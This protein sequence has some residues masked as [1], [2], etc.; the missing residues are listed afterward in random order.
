MVS[1]LLI[2]DLDYTLVR[3]NTTYEFLKLASPRRYMIFSKILFPL[4]LVNKIS[5]RDI[6]KRFLVFSCINQKRVEIL[7]N[8]AKAHFV[9]LLNNKSKHFNQ[10]VL[11][12]LEKND[13]AVILM[14][15]SLDIVAQ[16]F[17]EL[18]FLK[19]IGSE[20]YYKNGKFHWFHDLYGN[21]HLKIKMLSQNFKQITVIEDSL[22]KKYGRLNGI[23][24]IKFKQ[25]K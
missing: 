15:A 18:G 10:S 25:E 4:Y 7:R 14:T 23:T 17:I 1:K 21:K 13:A 20:T 11:N 8:Y 9:F 12:L 2:V 22:E 16:P 5:E 3:E 19:V 6:Y 24:V